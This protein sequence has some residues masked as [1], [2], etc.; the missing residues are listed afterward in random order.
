VNQFNTQDLRV[1]CVVHATGSAGTQAGLVVGMEGTRSQIPVL[2][3][4]VRAARE[5]QETNVYNLAVKT[6]ELL[7]V[8]GSVKRESVMANC[9]YV[10]GGY[11]VPTPG[12]VEAVTLMARLEGVLLD[13]VYSGKGMAGLID[14]CRKGHFKKG[15]NVVFLHTGGAVALYGYMDAFGEVYE[16]RS[17]FINFYG[18]P[19]RRPTPSFN[20]HVARLYWQLANAASDDN[21]GDWNSRIRSWTCTSCIASRIEMMAPPIPFSRRAILFPGLDALNSDVTGYAARTTTGAW[22]LYA[23]RSMGVKPSA[24]GSVRLQPALTSAVSA[25]RT[26]SSDTGAPS[27]GQS[28]K[29]RIVSFPSVSRAPSAT[30][31]GIMR[32]PTAARATAASRSVDSPAI[33][34]STGAPACTSRCTRR[35][36]QRAAR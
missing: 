17:P 7:G 31:A 4:G 16:G 15:E 2:G 14:L 3:I 30:S 1:D 35:A 36:D 23:A 8:P 33:L 26:S 29:A 22:A 27:T 25:A 34:P 6:A 11:G 9:D 13:P 20:P 5:A 21:V 10:G 19:A 12:M 18:A 28:A 32:T 24:S